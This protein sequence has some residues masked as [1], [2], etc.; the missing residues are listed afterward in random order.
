[1]VVESPL[2]KKEKEGGWGGGRE[3][4]SLLILEIVTSI[5]PLSLM[6]LAKRDDSQAQE[7]KIH[8]RSIWIYQ[9]QRNINNNGVNLITT[10]INEYY[11]INQSINNVYH[12]PPLFP[13]T[14]LTFFLSNFSKRR[15]PPDRSINSCGTRN[16]EIGTLSG[17]TWQRQ[18]ITR[19]YG[20]YYIHKLQPGTSMIY[21][22]PSILVCSLLSLPSLTS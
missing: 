21:P 22:I 14:S 9:K 8:F 5:H 18:S 17:I 15:N 16:E 2:G 4:R 12:H 7:K 19:E 1:M 10:M 11:L 3:L 20:I 6:R 13:F